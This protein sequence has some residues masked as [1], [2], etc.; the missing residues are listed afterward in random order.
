MWNVLKDMGVPQHLIVLMRNLYSRQE[1]TV[2][3]ECGEIEW[4]PV[5]KSVRQGCTLSP[6]LFNLY[7]E[8]IVRGAG[9]DED[10][11]RIKIGSRKINNLR[12]ADDTAVLA[13][14][15]D[16]L[17]WLVKK[18]KKESARA[19]LQLNLKKNE[20]NDYGNDKRL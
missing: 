20:S 1:A 19:G 6:Y 9:L 3:A 11:G 5:G 14:K 4:F 12:Y 18:L 16:D 7:A 13:D 8:H 17:K 2:R 15:L 10:E